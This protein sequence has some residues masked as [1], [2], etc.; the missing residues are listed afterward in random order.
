MKKE[1]DLSKMKRKKNPYSKRLKQQITLRVGTDVVDYFKELSEETGL[2]Y[3][4]LI[5]M[6]LRDCVESH[7][8][9]KVKWAS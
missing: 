3:Q 4:N 7:L 6:Y 1:Y 5:D 8:R 2:P 9:P